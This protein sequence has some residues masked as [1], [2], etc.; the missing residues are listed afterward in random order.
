MKFGARG[1]TALRWSAQCDTGLV[2]VGEAN[3][4]AIPE[5]R[6]FNQIHLADGAKNAEDGQI[7]PN[8]NVSGKRDSQF[9]CQFC[10]VFLER[11]MISNRANRLNTGLAKTKLGR[12]STAW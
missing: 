4:P 9:S 6:S 11:K 12:G 1:P 8:W 3:L 10:E 5:P 2:V 7:A